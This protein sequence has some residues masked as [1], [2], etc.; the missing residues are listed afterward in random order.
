VLYPIA[1]GAT[2]VLVAAFSALLFRET[3]TVPQGVGIVA[4]L[5]GI[6]RVYSTR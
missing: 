6:A 5:A 3:V 4:I 1:T 2:I